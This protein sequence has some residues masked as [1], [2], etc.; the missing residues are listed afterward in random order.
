M[1]RFDAPLLARAWLAVAIAAGSDKDD[2]QTYKTIVIEEHTTGVRLVATDRWL[3]LTAWVPDLEHLYGSGSREPHIATLP[4]ARVVVAD[5]DGRGRSMLGHLLALAARIPE[6]SY[7]PGDVEVGLDLNVRAAAAPGAQEGFEG[8]DPLHVRLRSPDVETVYVPTLD[9]AAVDWRSAIDQH[10]PAPT[11]EVQYHPE[12]L[13]RIGKVRRH[14]EGP[15]RLTLGK[16]SPTRLVFPKS[17]P[18]VWGVFITAREQEEVIE[19]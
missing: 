9:M 7:T 12:L 2:P 11:S 19:A 10:T 18:E 14:A 8:M 17:D 15:V 1:S 13:D 5:V 4:D 16:T 3:V 6:A